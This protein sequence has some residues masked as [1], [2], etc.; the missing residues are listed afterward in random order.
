[1]YSETENMNFE[2]NRSSLFSVEYLYVLVIFIVFIICICNS[3]DW[4]GGIL[5]A[6]LGLEERERRPHCGAVAEIRYLVCP[7]PTTNIQKPHG[8]QFYL[9]ATQAFNLIC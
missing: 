7:K 6:Y 3:R 8:F 1:M 4:E 5:G 9:R 2:A